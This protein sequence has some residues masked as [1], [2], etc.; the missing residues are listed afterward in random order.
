MTSF[1]LSDLGGA[2]ELIGNEKLAVVQGGYN[3]RTTTGAVSAALF[4]QPYVRI[5]YEAY[6]DFYSPYSITIGFQSETFGSYAIA[7][8][9]RTA[10]IFNGTAVGYWCGAIGSGLALGSCY[11]N[12]YAPVAVG[13]Y[14]VAHGNFGIALG[15]NTQSGLKSLS[16][17]YSAQTYSNYAIAIGNFA[18]SYANN[19]TVAIGNFS[20]SFG[21]GAIG[22]GYRSVG[23][24]RSVA[25]GGYA[26][27]NR[28]VPDYGVRNVSIGYYAFGNTYWNVAIGAYSVCFN[29][30]AATAIGHRAPVLSPNASAF[31]YVPFVPG[32]AAV[33]IGSCGALSNF[34]MAIGH[35]QAS[36][37]TASI[38]L[39]N[40]LND[41]TAGSLVIAGNQTAPLRPTQHFQKFIGRT[42]IDNPT[43]VLTADGGPVGDR[44]VVALAIPS[45]ASVTGRVTAAVDS[46]FDT[47]GDCAS[48]VL[49][50]CT[51]IRQSN[52]VYTF[53]GTPTF[54]LENNTIG[55]SSWPVPTLTI[56][57]SRVIIT[58]NNSDVALN[59]MAHVTLETSN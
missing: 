38:V 55:A 24:Y 28:Y 40:N 47:D 19:Y 43:C 2:S 23:N 27:F 54:T 52:G 35:Y 49:A 3:V 42:T 14:T 57:S 36:Y 6:H 26:Q 33:A 41:Q 18:N 39:G 30:P 8:G 22:I 9:H 25:I 45:I 11:T 29:A 53:V 50:P 34:S 17:G 21:D 44:L 37:N 12:G 4:T 15:C 32:G 58:V 7:V 20:H 16:M 10:G 13:H 1:K 48:F 31:G 59:W 46:L 56:D 51:I 5:G